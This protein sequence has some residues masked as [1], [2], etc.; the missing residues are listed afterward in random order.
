MPLR[1]RSRFLSL[2]FS[3]A[4]R[5][6]RVARGFSPGFSST[7]NRLSPGGAA[8]QRTS[9]LPSPLQG[10][11]PFFVDFP[12]AEA[13]GYMP[14]SLRDKQ[15]A[16]LQN[17]RFGLRFWGFT[18][19]LPCN[20]PLDFGGW[21]GPSTDRDFNSQPSLNFCNRSGPASTGFLSYP[22]LKTSLRL[23]TRRIGTDN[24]SAMG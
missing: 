17:S 21:H 6:W 13:P 14:P 12:G 1:P 15:T 18:R 16:Q 2:R 22:T 23:K 19:K 24:R 9:D 3:A 11:I 4:E 5:R 20:R 8:E 10:F 7:K